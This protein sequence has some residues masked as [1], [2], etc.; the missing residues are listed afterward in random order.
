LR[1]VTDFGTDLIQRDV[2]HWLHWQIGRGKGHNRTRRQGVP[3]ASAAD[4][5]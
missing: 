2:G 4:R 3:D 5:G 1:R